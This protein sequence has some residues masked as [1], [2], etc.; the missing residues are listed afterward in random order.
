MCRKHTF[1]DTRNY[2]KQILEL[3]YFILATLLRMKSRH[4]LNIVYNYLPMPSFKVLNM[5]VVSTYFFVF[6][7]KLKHI[8]NARLQDALNDG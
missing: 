2:G 8:N 6:V 5:H 4:E 1:V 7:F 3:V